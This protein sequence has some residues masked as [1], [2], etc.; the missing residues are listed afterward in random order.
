MAYGSVRAGGWEAKEGE[1]AAG[2]PALLWT[3]KGQVEDLVP[4][5]PPAM[6]VAY[7]VFVV[8]GDGSYAIS[9]PTEG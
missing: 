7:R 3:Q 2:R 8:A 4:V 9:T 5:A 6:E 1:D